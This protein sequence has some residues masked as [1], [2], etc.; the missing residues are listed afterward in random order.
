M[1]SGWVSRTSVRTV[2]TERQK[3]GLF[4]AIPASDAV[5]LTL[6]LL[7]KEKSGVGICVIGIFIADAKYGATGRCDPTPST[8]CVT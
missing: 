6:R 8:T 2:R 4:R 1:T 7:V 5:R 3:A